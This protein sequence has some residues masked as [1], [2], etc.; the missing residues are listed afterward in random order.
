[1]IDAFLCAYIRKSEQTV[2]VQIMKYIRGFEMKDFQQ[3]LTELSNVGLLTFWKA[4]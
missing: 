1:M 3:R 2:S 4:C